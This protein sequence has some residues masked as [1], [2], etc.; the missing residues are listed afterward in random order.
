MDEYHDLK[1]EVSEPN[2]TVRTSIGYY[3]QPVFYDQ[4]PAGIERVTVAQL[5]QALQNDCMLIRMLRWHSG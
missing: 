3:D 2:L 1:V 5:E 4:L